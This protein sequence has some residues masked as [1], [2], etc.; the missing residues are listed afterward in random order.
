MMHREITEEQA[1]VALQILKQECGYRPDQ[2]DGPVFVRVITDQESPCH[3][4][5]FIGNLGFGGKFRN[6]GN[7]GN[8]PYV[9]CYPEDETPER[10]VMI[11]RA[12]ERLSAVF[13]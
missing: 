9:D 3:E 6:N 10:L 5:R 12:N 1:E 4:W 13:E 8:V 2:Y 11:E 7:R